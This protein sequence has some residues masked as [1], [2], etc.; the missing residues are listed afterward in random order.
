M[1]TQPRFAQKS[2]Q[3]TEDDVKPAPKKERPKKFSRE[4]RI[5]GA[6]A[7]QILTELAKENRPIGNGVCRNYRE[8][9]LNGQWKEGASNGLVFD[10]HGK[11][12]DGYHRLTA[13][14]DA[15]E[16][17]PDI[18]LTFWITYNED[19]DTFDIYDQPKRRTIAD[20]FALDG[21]VVDEGVSHNKITAIAKRVL[22][23]L[24]A[25]QP[26]SGHHGAVVSD[27]AI[28]AFAKKHNQL[29]LKVFKAARHYKGRRYNAGWPSAFAKAALV[30]GFD[31]VGPHLERFANQS[32]YGETDPLKRLHLRL[33]TLPAGAQDYV[34]YPY[35]VSAVRAAVEQRQMAH[36]PPA[37]TDFQLKDAKDAA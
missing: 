3:D 36:L 20:K 31:V 2:Q 35:A 17:K 23:G 10:W 27:A 5:D 15:S 4:E 11:L 9:M 19:P 21:G 6:K 22:V 30:Y 16:V 32:W 1:A 37:E 34:L 29:F 13:L 24:S 18:A 26:D 12:H 28:L 7:Y 33:S 25:G 8:L 14:C